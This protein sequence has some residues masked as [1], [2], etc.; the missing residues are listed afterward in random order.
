MISNG[1]NPLTRAAAHSSPAGRGAGGEG[2]AW[3]SCEHAMDEPPP[4]PVSIEPEFFSA[5]VAADKVIATDVVAIP[6]SGLDAFRAGLELELRD[7]RIGADRAW[8][9]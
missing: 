6:P 8:R 5:R 9:G 4:S 2:N 1:A 3:L 7:C